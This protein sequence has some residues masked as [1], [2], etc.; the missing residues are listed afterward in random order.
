MLAL[1][2]I[3]YEIRAFIARGGRVL[4]TSDE[5]TGWAGALITL[6]L[7]LRHPGDPPPPDPVLADLDAELAAIKRS[8]DDEHE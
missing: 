2:M 4:A 5:E 6:R 7:L 3:G 8:D 1:Q